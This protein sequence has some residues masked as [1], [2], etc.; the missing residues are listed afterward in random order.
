M[1]DRPT[2]VPSDGA[3][4][5]DGRVA[6]APWGVAGRPMADL[7]RSGSHA[8]MHSRRAPV[9]SPPFCLERPERALDPNGTQVV[10]VRAALSP[11]ALEERGRRRREREE[12]TRRREAQGGEERANRQARERGS[13]ACRLLGTNCLLV[14]PERGVDSQEAG[15]G[16]H[17]SSR[18]VLES[19]N[20]RGQPCVLALKSGGDDSCRDCSEEFTTEPERTSVNMQVLDNPAG[21]LRSLLPWWGLISEVE[22]KARARALQSVPQDS[23]QTALN[24]TDA[25]SAELSPCRFNDLDTPLFD[26]IFRFQLDTGNAV[27]TDTVYAYL[28]GLIGRLFYD[29]GRFD[30]FD[31]MP[32]VVGDTNTGK[33][34]LVD[35][36]AAMFASGRIGVVDSSHE[37]TFGL[38]SMYDKE[39]IVCQEM[40]DNMAQL[41]ASDKIKKMICGE[42]V[43]V[44]IKHAVAD[45]H[46]GK[47]G[48]WSACPDYFKLNIAN[49]HENTD[50]LHMFLTLGCG[51]NIWFDKHT[52]Y[53]KTE[54]FTAGNMPGVQASSKERLLR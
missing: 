47:A 27:E 24:S 43:A 7:G 15:A 25:T 53:K 4:T 21:V 19:V 37:T 35:V 33:S 13:L 49:M 14:L 5:S 11:E 52:G 18:G 23:G 39:H 16:L 26:R 1:S 51:D 36:V 45:T 50:Y 42:Q 2:T 3:R 40:P 8:C 46:T 17:R 9:Q 34:T 22:T 48:F 31:V 28:L 12:I 6:E 20:Y 10:G 41:L 44:P 54:Y 38:Q 32:F 30:T 29:V